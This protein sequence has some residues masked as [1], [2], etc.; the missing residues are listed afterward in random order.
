[1]KKL[2][3]VVAAAATLFVGCSEEE[4]MIEVRGTVTGVVTSTV[5][6]HE[7]LDEV[8][9]SWYEGA[10]A[11]NFVTKT[12]GVYSIPNV[13]PGT[14][15]IAFAKEGYA[16]TTVQATVENPYL[17]GGANGGGTMPV[18]EGG[19]TVQAIARADASLAPLNGEI[20]A[21]L[22][23]AIGSLKQPLADYDVKVVV[24]GGVYDGGKTNTDG[25]FTATKVPAG[26]ASIT[27]IATKGD[28]QYTATTTATVLAG[29]PTNIT[30]GGNGTGNV[31]ASKSTPIDGI[32]SANFGVEDVQPDATLSI[33][34][35]KALRTPQAVT[36]TIRN[37]NTNATY[38]NIATINGSTLTV[39]PHLPLPAGTYSIS[40]SQLL[41]AD[42]NIVNVSPPSI[43]VAQNELYVT[44]SNLFD[45]GVEATNSQP[46]IFT[47]PNEDAL[48]ITFTFNEAVKADAD[49][50]VEGNSLYIY[51]Y[52][53]NSNLNAQAYSFKTDAT[54]K[55]VTLTI[56]K[57]ALT[58]SNTYSISGTII[59]KDKATA[60]A[61]LNYYFTIQGNF[62]LATS[63][64]LA[65]GAVATS[66]K[67]TEVKLPATDALEITLT[68]NK[69]VKADADGKVE[70][71]NLFIYNYNSSSYLDAQTYSFKTDATEEIVTLTIQKNALTVGTTYSISGTIIS[72][73]NEAATASLN[74]YYFKVTQGD[75][76]LATS[77][78]LDNGAAATSGTPTKLTLSAAAPT[79][80][81]TLT[82]N[83][84]V[85]VDAQ[86]NVEG[87]YCNVSNYAAKADATGKVVTV[88]IPRGEF[89]SATT[90]R[91]V[92]GNISNADDESESVNLPTLYFDVVREAFGFVSTNLK[93][94]ANGIFATSNSYKEF[95]HTA[96]IAFE[97]TFN[98]PV[99]ADPN[100]VVTGLS[101]NGSF[102]ATYSSYTPQYQS[103]VLKT[104]DPKTVVVT[105]KK[106]LLQA[107]SQYY[108]NGSVYAAD[109]T[110]GSAANV[111]TLYFNTQGPD[112]VKVGRIVVDSFSYNNGTYD[113][114]D[115][116]IYVK[117]SLNENPTYT[118]SNSTYEFQYKNSVSGAW[119]TVSPNSPSVWWDE[120]ATG[121]QY[122]T[123]SFNVSNFVPGQSG[124][125]FANSKEIL[126]RVRAVKGSGAAR[127]V[128]AW[129]ELPTPVKDNTAPSGTPT[130]YSYSG[131][132]NNTSVSESTATVYYNLPPSWETNNTSLVPFDGTLK[133]G[134]DIEIVDA[135]VT[136]VV[137]GSI[138]T[139]SVRV[140]AGVDASNGYFTIKVK[141]S[142]NNESADITVTL[143]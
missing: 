117:W 90:N 60:T 113:Y 82:F 12:D 56:Q 57:N 120:S 40:T 41:Y 29:A 20:K 34:F 96:D 101:I 32:L 31:V 61:P 107:N 45:G 89:T 126:V 91:Q 30:N 16:P 6:T 130:Y 127:K 135:E 134:G 28:A 115:N 80:S 48:T 7:P 39:K 70:G 104:G 65:N 119:V 83:K 131:T 69:P 13:P 123:A 36:A 5:G 85:K 55:I 49:G 66:S 24:N 133:D 23:E 136:D 141:D 37:L 108:I 33:T 111:S 47:L 50:K 99:K 68:F 3:L 95:P 14:I 121:T 19:G 105:I 44:A 93:D 42:G 73:D 11:K 35:L 52:N 118:Y 63:S 25:A 84:K 51:N 78:L 2:L 94:E 125:P 22:Y 43:S 106:E 9:V 132:L 46:R 54:G 10:T 77:S 15:S 58:A 137:I 62:Y 72:K 102:N 76:Y 138:I 124:S 97:L 139:V 67:P 114:N 109:Q 8:T 81:F 98:A 92:W 1:M 75:F 38:A 110:D 17:V 79:I 140:G 142:S 129:T 86:G 27:V 64:L 4:R 53:S 71:N 18:V 103:F 59:S 87:L 74:N 100:G 143:P 112:P 116:Y 128:S 122:G 26:S 88:T 21:R